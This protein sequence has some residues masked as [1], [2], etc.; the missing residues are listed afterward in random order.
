MSSA[1]GARTAQLRELL[2]DHGLDALI[3]SAPTNIR[4]ITGFTGSNGT[5]LIRPDSV[6]LITDRRYT[7]WA[8]DEI[9]AHAPN[10]DVVIASGNGLKEL[11]RLL[12]SAGS[13]GLE[14]GHISWTDAESFQSE[15]GRERVVATTGAIE[16]L[17]EF[18]TEHEIAQLRAAAEVGDNALTLLIDELRPGLT[19][20][21]VARRLAQHMF[22]IAGAV[23]SFEIIVASGPNSAKPHHEPTDRVIQAGDLLIIDSGATVNGYRSDMTRSFVF[24]PP[25]SQQQEML[26]VVLVAQQ[27]GVDAVRP[28]VG[29]SEIDSTC[30]TSITDA[31]YGEYFTHGTGHGVGLDIHE[32]PSVSSSSTATLA[33]GHIVTVEPGVYIP[34]VGGV[35]WEDTVAVTT[36]GAEPLTRSPK[37]PLITL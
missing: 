9:E 4:Y 34:D 36:V 31:G 27:A 18:K 14:A 11:E 16:A 19:E 6:Q 30:R 33:P 26:D 12:E 15:F 29:T 17:R 23:P 21:D 3:V 28:G 1:G 25:T 8:A 5:V 7:K 32:A 37:Q 22:D 2:D 10:V 13:I 20:V 24:G 35:R